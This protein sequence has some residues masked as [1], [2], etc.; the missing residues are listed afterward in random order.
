MKL[1]YLEAIPD[2]A[3]GDLTLK[4]TRIRVELVLIRLTEV[5]ESFEELHEMWPHVSIKKLKGAVKEAIEFVGML[6]YKN[7]N[8]LSETYEELRT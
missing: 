7:L 1:K 6:N 5:G 3:S 4:G 8:H 2:R